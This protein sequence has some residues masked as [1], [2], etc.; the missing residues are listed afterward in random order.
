M[1]SIKC[2]NGGFCY[3]KNLEAYCACPDGYFC[4]RCE[5]NLE[6]VGSRA[7]NLV[8]DFLNTKDIGRITNRWWIM[9]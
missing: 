3:M 6:V 5:L 2:E 7:K 8:D 9:I 4:L 1:W